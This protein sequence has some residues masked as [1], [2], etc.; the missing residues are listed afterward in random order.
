MVRRGNALDRVSGESARSINFSL[1]IL[2]QRVG[3]LEKIL[4][5]APAAY[6]VDTKGIIRFHL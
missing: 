5:S 3:E 2:L 6:L 4:T 1:Q